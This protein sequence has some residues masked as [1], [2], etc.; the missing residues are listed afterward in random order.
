MLASA[1]AR[2]SAI[3]TRIRG[4]SFA[5]F[6]DYDGTLT[7]IAARPELATLDEDQR[8]LLRRVAAQHRVA[9]VTGR[10]MGDVR[11]L[12]GLP[13]L[14]YAANHGFEITGPDVS[15]EVDP[16]LRGVFEQV[17]AEVTDRVGG[18]EGVVLESKGYGVAV[19]YRLADRD[20]VPG[21]EAVVDE[22]IA[23]SERLRKGTGKEVFEI[24]PALAWHKGAAV[25]WLLERWGA[26]VP[27]YIGDDRTDEDGFV[28]AAARNGFGIV[29]G[30]PAWTTCATLQL[31][32]PA[33]VGQ[34][35]CRFLPN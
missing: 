2:W 16:E 22:I 3:A 7:P 31:R 9:I 10:A 30:T 14:H 25:D 20:V 32:D 5:I 23:G 17:A 29:V 27:I 28:T 4:E 34:F 13:A 11:R 12:V 8:D 24:R 35:L 21:I 18:I 26:S 1:L 15:F 19:H 33:E 6:L